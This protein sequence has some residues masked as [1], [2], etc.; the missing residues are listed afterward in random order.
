[1]HD[2]YLRRH[3]YELTINRLHALKAAT[4][5]K[6]S[7]NKRVARQ[8]AAAVRYQLARMAF[9]LEMDEVCCSND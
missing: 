3:F 8:P 6:M 7:F 5:E 9:E 4:K 1:M 2:M